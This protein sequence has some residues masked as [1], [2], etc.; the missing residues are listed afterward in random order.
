MKK[1]LD[2]EIQPQP[3][4]SSCGPTCLSAVYQYWSDPV[5]I[6]CLLNEIRQLSSGGT[7]AVQLGCHALSRGYHA[8]ITTYKLQIFDPTWF[9]SA[10]GV[11]NSL[12]ISEKLAKQFE[13]KSKRPHVNHA[14]LKN[15]TDSYIHFLKL[16]GRL[17]MV[18]LNEQLIQ[19]AIADGVPVLCGLSATYLYQESR[20][21]SDTGAP[22]GLTSVDD[23]V[24]GD[25]SGH[26]VVIYGYDCETSEVSIADPL[27]SNPFAPTNKYKAPLSRV[28]AAILLGIV[29]YDANVLMVYPRDVQLSCS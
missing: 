19:D 18:P 9:K 6:Q 26:F 5:E 15:A 8:M 28:V 3:N 23:D 14:R 21:R 2:L 11:G 27:Q 10:G 29:T 22:N 17:R 25:P 4:D 20:E 16:G 7:L 12:Q 13:I 24:G 1:T